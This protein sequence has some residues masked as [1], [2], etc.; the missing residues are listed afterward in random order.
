ME[1]EEEDSTSILTGKWVWLGGS[2]MRPVGEIL[3]EKRKTQG[4]SEDL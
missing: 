1:L 4:I 2:E 3:S